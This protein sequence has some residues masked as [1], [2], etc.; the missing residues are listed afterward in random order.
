[1]HG[2]IMN[3]PLTLTSILHRPAACIVIPTATSI[4]A[5]CA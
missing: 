4:T 1:M 5:C 2:L 3:Y